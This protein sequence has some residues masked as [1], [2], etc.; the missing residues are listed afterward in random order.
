M[1]DRKKEDGKIFLEPANGHY[2]RIELTP[3][4]NVKLLKVTMVLSKKGSEMK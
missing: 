4:M 2:E 1:A 3:D